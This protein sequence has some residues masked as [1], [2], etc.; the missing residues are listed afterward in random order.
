MTTE[1]FRLEEQT[2]ASAEAGQT[3]GGHAREA[4]PR[5]GGRL[6]IIDD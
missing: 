4:V 3:Y 2:R 6:L 5:T 1:R